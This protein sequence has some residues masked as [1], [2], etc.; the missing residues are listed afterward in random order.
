[1]AGYD[2]SIRAFADRSS[3]PGR[4]ACAAALEV[5]VSEFF[6]RIG[7]AFKCLFL[8]LFAGRLPEGIPER[9]RAPGTA[10]LETGRNGTG[11]TPVSAPPSGAAAVQLLALL[12]RDGRLVDFL[13]EEIGTYPDDQVGVAARE[14]HA[15]CRQVL[16]KYV[17]L[18]P[19]LA[20]DEGSLAAVGADFDPAEIKL[21]GHV[22]GA[23][24]FRGVLRHRGWRASRVNLPTV[25][26]SAR[27]AVIA[28]AEV[29][30][31]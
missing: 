27:S 14:V 28:P 3:A 22:T 24:P 21:L 31:G 13:C 29:E 10:P 2:G 16:L 8:I 1:M 9:F 19:I 25:P 4:R 15:A 7:L 30:L 18:E 5:H 11:D 23:P 17:G 26:G 6:Q 12:Q 20:G